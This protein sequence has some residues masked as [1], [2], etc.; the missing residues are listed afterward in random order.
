[1]DETPHP[2]VDR[3][4]RDKDGAAVLSS[5]ARRVAPPLFLLLSVAAAAATLTL[6]G[7][8]SPAPPDPALPVAIAGEARS[9]RT[10]PL[11]PAIDNWNRLRQSDRLPFDDY[12]GFLTAHRGWPGEIGLR[13]A[14]ERQIMPD[15][16]DPARVAAFFAI[17]PPLTQSGRVRHAEALASLGRSAEARD[18]AAAAWTDG[19]LSPDD[20]G[21]LTARFAGQFTPAEQDQRMERLLWDRAVA[22]AI[23]QIAFVSPGRR[24]L[25]AARLAYQAKAPDARLQ[26]SSAGTTADRDA[27]YLID[28]AIWL[29]DTG[30]W[31]QARALLAQPRTL[32]APPFDAQRYLETLLTFARAAAADNQATSAYGIAANAD[33]AFATGIDI[34]QRPL[35]ERDAYTSLAWLGGTTALNKLGRRRD[36]AAMFRRYAAAAQTAGSRARGNYWAGWAAGAAGDSAA[37]DVDYA[38]AATSMDQFYG[39]LAAEKLGRAITLP[40]DPPALEIAPDARAAFR[41][42]E[43]VRA[44][45]LT[46]QQRQWQDQTQFVRQIAADAKSDADHALV[47]E[48][49]RT[50]ARPD[51]GV[52]LSRLP[53]DGARDPIRVAFPTM[54]VPSPYDADWT[55]IHA[56][57]RQESQFDREALSPA[58]AHG[59]MQLMNPTAREQA[60]KIGLPW[61]PSR[62]VTD[63]TY[64]ITIGAS[65]IDRQIAY[66]QGS[67]VLAI[68]SYNAGPGNVNKFIRANGDPR[69][70][71]VDMIDWIEAI[72]ISET[73]AYV[74]KVLENAVVYDLLNPHRDGA[75]ERKR[76]E[77]YL[78]RR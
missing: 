58:G 35:P 1:M 56:I 54:P 76:L 31:T 74:Q 67:Y 51:L 38:R 75:P 15:A 45:R 12:A 20:E 50:I 19:A 60:G 53:R 59:L 17:D 30:G 27:G 32:D 37:A 14:A 70:P 43:V 24:P 66:Y 22:S 52:I 21:R 64:N 72:P 48:L 33:D 7:S 29:R 11:W 44:A 41:Q 4:K 8:T 9:P 2:N 73:R 13:K 65:F 18:A 40:V 3:A 47:G 57:A 36:A 23:R 61:E 62:L 6:R 71:G 25:Y 78:G 77:H 49:A 69:Q 26:A 39:Q 34:S 63:P 55:M 28:R 68:A 16:A 46:G 5:M 10:D 42:R